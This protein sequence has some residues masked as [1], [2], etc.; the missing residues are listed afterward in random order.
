MIA[1]KRC[2]VSSSKG[3]QYA[4][5]AKGLKEVAALADDVIRIDVVCSCLV[6]F[7]IAKRLLPGLVSAGCTPTRNSYIKSNH[8]TQISSSGALR[9]GPRMAEQG[10]LLLLPRSGALVLRIEHIEQLDS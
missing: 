7:C 1:W 4:L 10:R 3:V 5:Q 9:E 2:L 8:V 6:R